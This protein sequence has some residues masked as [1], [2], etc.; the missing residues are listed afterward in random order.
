MPNSTIETIK[1]IVVILTPVAIAFIGYKQ[2]Q[3]SNRQKVIHAQ[4]DGM[5]SELVEA[6][7]GRGEA[8]GQLAGIAQE[9]AAAVVIKT[10]VVQEVKIVEQAKPIDVKIDESEKK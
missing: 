4:I 6:V 10:P 1:D 3:I 2:A 5:K 8:E 7:K 9:K